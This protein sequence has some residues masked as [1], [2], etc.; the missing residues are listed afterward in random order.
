MKQ[1]LGLQGFYKITVRGPDGD[2]RRQLEFPNLITNLGLNGI[3]TDG[4]SWMTKVALGTGTGAPAVGDTSL[5]GTVVQTTESIASGQYTSGTVT[6][7][8]QYGY[9][10]YSAVFTQGQATGT[11]T[12]V[13]I[14]R[15]STTLW[16]RA[17]ILDGGGNSTSLTIQAIEQLTVE[18]ELRCYMNLNDVTGNVTIS[19]TSYAY[20]IRPFNQLYPYWMVQGGWM[21]GAGTPSYAV[22]VYN[23]ALNAAWVDPSGTSSTINGG[24]VT[25]AAYSSNSYTKVVTDTWPIDYGNL[26]GGVTV[27]MPFIIGDANNG[28][29]G[30]NFKFGFNP[31]LPKDNTKTMSLTFSYTWSRY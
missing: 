5:S 11:W 24:T 13:G 6:G 19:G 8:P 28:G 22:A 27:V 9:S 2:I 16:S 30:R 4:T 7:P 17:L 23:G 20:T 15:N 31:A 21:Y 29:G 18:Y 12:E 26:S 25:V 3:G 10:R 1:K 14:G